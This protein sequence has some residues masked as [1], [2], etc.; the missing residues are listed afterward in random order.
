MALTVTGS[1]TPGGV[2]TF[3][4]T[5]TAGLPVVLVAGAAASEL[6]VKR[7]G[8]L[9]VDLSAPFLILPFGTIPNS[10]NL[11]VPPSLPVPLTVYL[12]EAALAPGAGN[13]GNLV[14]L[15]IE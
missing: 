5:G 6:A 2:L 15:E 9:F 4:T 12:Q 7:L 13:F 11:T 1:A 14:T 10:Q 8:A 3:D